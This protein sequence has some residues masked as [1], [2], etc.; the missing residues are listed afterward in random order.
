MSSIYQSLTIRDFTAAVTMTCIDLLC[1]SKQDVGHRTNFPPKFLSCQSVFLFPVEETVEEWQELDGS[2]QNP[3]FDWWRLWRIYLQWLQWS[4][5]VWQFFFKCH[6]V[7]SKKVFF[8]IHRQCFIFN[9]KSLFWMVVL[10][11]LMKY[12]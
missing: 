8:L 11:F 6:Y 1:C 12:V 10:N 7:K 9:H 3:H 4:T 2:G 5:T